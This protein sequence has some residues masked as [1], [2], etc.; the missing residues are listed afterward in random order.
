LFPSCSSGRTVNCLADDN[1]LQL[2]LKSTQ[3]AAK[4]ELRSLVMRLRPSW[5]MRQRSTS[6]HRA[7]MTLPTASRD[8]RIYEHALISMT[9]QGR[10]RSRSMES[11]AHHLFAIPR[12][13]YRGREG[14]STV[15]CAPLPATISVVRHPPLAAIVA[16][17]MR[18]LTVFT[19]ESAPN[20]SEKSS[21]NTL[22]RSHPDRRQPCGAAMYTT[23][24][25][26]G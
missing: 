4:V 8:G 17:V 3:R 13:A 1:P 20:T 18:R 5:G 14:S 2:Y 11:T 23:S 12:E 25:T 21:P 6:A 9:I 16:E 7:N 10:T 22:P 19:A 15:I 26:R 24:S